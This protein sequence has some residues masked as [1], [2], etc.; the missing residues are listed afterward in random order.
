MKNQNTNQNIT[1][2]LRNEIYMYMYIFKNN[3][4][5]VL[6]SHAYLE[7]PSCFSSLQNKSILYKQGKVICVCV[8]GGGL[9]SKCLDTSGDI[10]V[11]RNQKG[12]SFLPPHYFKS[13]LVFNVTFSGFIIW[14]LI[15]TCLLP[16]AF[17]TNSNLNLFRG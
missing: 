15:L 9:Q 16:I 10:V 6:L 11:I 14:A 17:N 1:R 3:T 5:T 7:N 4:I 2:S 8:W 12:N 13:A